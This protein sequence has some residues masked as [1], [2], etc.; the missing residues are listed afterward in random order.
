MGDFA[1]SNAFDLL[2]GTEKLHSLDCSRFFI[3]Y[4]IC[5]RSKSALLLFCGVSF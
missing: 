2:V 3:I 5:V 4:C 1:F